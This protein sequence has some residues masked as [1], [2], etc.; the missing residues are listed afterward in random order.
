MIKK[1]TIIV[2]LS[3]VVLGG[4]VYYFDWKRGNEEKPA[5]NASKSAFSIQASDIKSITLTHPAEPSTPPIRLEKSGDTWNIVQPIETQ[6]DQPT[7]DGIADQLASARVSETEPGSPDRRKVYGLD[8]PQVSLE[9]QL[10]NGSK[11]TILI[12]SKDFSGDSAYTV[13]DG[14]QNV[15][16]LPQLLATSAGKS[17]EDLRDR[18][19]LHIDAAG[20]SS[21]DLAN[22]SGQL[23][24][25]KKND[26]WHFTKPGASLADPDATDG[27]LQAV[28]NAKMASIVEE[29]PEHLDR[30]G[31]QKPAITFSAKEGKGSPATLIVGKKSGSGYYARDASRP[32]VFTITNDVYAKLTQ[33]YAELRD[34][35][36]VNVPATDM[37]QIQISDAA[38]S[39]TVSRKKDDSEDWTFQAPEQQKGKAA[40][41][42]KIVD[43][44]TGLTADQIIDHPSPAD[45][46]SLAN[47]ETTVVVTNAKGEKITIRFSKATGEFVYAQTSDSPSLYELKKGAVTDLNLKPADLTP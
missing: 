27:L 10:R 22:P 17:V 42:W 3:A 44:L 16:L 6:A 29:K 47:P 18:N 43:V 21:F 19:I 40:S 14:A 24:A 25:S 13:I 23:A 41:G 33:K 12:G 31:L 9:F 4:L 11:H 37:Q 46:K 38:G 8:P 39:L 20:V 28:A 35:K 45:L 1:P 32:T 15:S 5:I 34:K 2:L 30:Y 36:V 7:V 26:Q